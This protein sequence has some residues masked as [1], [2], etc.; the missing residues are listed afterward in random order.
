MANPTDSF[1]TR[2][3]VPEKYRWNLELIYP[4]AQAWEKDFSKIDSVAQKME[5]FRGK[6]ATK[7][8]ATL[9]QAYDA[10]TD[11]DL[12]IERLYSFRITV[13]TKTR[14]MQKI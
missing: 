12:I 3:E 14:V 5:Q 10:Q 9:K 1:K 13:Q 2:S 4:D 8:P 11:L 6:L 7:T